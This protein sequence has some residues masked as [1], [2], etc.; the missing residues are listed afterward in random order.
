[1]IKKVSIILTLLLCVFLSSNAIALDVTPQDPDITFIW[2]DSDLAEVVG[3]KLYWSDTE[4]EGYVN[5]LSVDGQPLVFIY[6]PDGPACTP[7]DP[8]VA[9]QGFVV[10]TTPRRYKKYFRLTAFTV[11]M[12]SFMSDPAVDKDG[13]KEIWFINPLGRPFGVKVKLI[14][15]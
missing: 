3:F 6:D 11:D 9:E 8:C 4:V 10:A 2:D 7:D 13:I 1:M 15:Q 14:R 12:E 5:V